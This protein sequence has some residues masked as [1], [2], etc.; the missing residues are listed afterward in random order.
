MEIDESLKEVVERG[1]YA[2]LAFSA[3]TLAIFS[4]FKL[5]YLNDVYTFFGSAMLADGFG[6]FPSNIDMAWETRPVIHRILYYI[7]FKISECTYGDF[8]LFALL[9]KTIIAIMVLVTCWYFAC[10]VNRYYKT[11]PHKYAT[12]LIASLSLFT[13]HLL[14]VNVTEFFAVLFTILLIGLLLSENKYAHIAAGFV[15][16]FII[17]LKIVTIIYVLLAILAW[18][19]ITQELNKNKLI[20]C[21]VGVGAATILFAVLCILW[22]KNFIPDTLL[23]LE[24]HNPGAGVS[25]LI[26]LYFMFRTV[27]SSWWFIPISTVGIILGIIVIYEYV[28]SGQKTNA[29][30]LITLWILSYS[31]VYIQAEWSIIHC[32]G[33][34]IPSITTIILFLS[35]NFKKKQIIFVTIM[36]FILMCFF[37]VSSSTWVDPHK[38]MWAGQINTTTEMKEKFN[39]SNQPKI[40]YADTGISAYFI[41]V[42]SACRETYPWVVRSGYKIGLSDHP[43]Y[44]HAKQ[45]IMNYTGEYILYDSG[46]TDPE[47]TQKIST[48]YTKVYDGNDWG[49]VY[50]PTD[51]YKRNY[52][53]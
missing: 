49:V 22:F 13:L 14:L 52:G 9:T 48:E 45:C 36:V 39:L 21:G 11:N 46:L 27:L 42:K 31:Q 43:A 28:K 40:L 4:Y 18:V 50:D 23:M 17:L 51:L 20:R 7:I 29:A 38:D 26:K 19:L 41:G 10:G 47:I 30:L 24:L 25:I 35:L 53:V 5:S 44:I 16:L 32:A 34:I 2:L 8:E 15:I 3:L 1:L 12:V 6:A 37:G 33:V